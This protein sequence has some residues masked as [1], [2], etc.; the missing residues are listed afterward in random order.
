[1]ALQLKRLFAYIENLR[2]GW[3]G[4]FLIA[5]AVIFSRVLTEGIFDSQ[6]IFSYSTVIFWQ[7]WFFSLCICLIIFV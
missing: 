1:M 7:S 5:N 3:L 2:I 6:T 4:I